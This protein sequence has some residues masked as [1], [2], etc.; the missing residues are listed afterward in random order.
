VSLR[1]G[2]IEQTATLPDGREI[3]VRVGLFDGG[4]VPPSQIDTVTLDLVVGDE[5][6]ATV[7]TVLRPDEVSEALK[8]AREI[9]TQLE[10]GELEPTA[11]SI[12]HVAL[13]IPD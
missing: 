10:A 12:E 8:L 3:V 7:E 6:Q 4:Y 2:P 11:G 13:T 1:A 9:A 5:V